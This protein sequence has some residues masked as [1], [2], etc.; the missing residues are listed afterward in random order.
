MQQKDSLVMGEHPPSH[1]Q[2]QSTHPAMPDSRRA[3]PGGEGG[4]GTWPC[5]LAAQVGLGSSSLAPSSPAAV[6]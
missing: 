2:T 3:G 6:H 4:N 5:G 1:G